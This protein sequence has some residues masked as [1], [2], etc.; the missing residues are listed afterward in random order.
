MDEQ[1][2]RKREHLDNSPG[3]ESKL[4]QA[5]RCELQGTHESTEIQ[6]ST[7]Q[8]KGVDAPSKQ[9]HGTMKKIDPMKASGSTPKHEGEISAGSGDMK[10][11]FHDHDIAEQQ[12]AEGATGGKVQQSTHKPRDVNQKFTPLRE[13][14]L[15]FLTNS[16]VTILESIENTIITTPSSIACYDH[17][18]VVCFINFHSR[19]IDE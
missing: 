12:D 7:S 2:F 11:T 5:A 3:E 4:L 15:V 6:S 10:Q 18:D 8:G 14:L 9:R 19:L 17:D 16:E 13:S 1:S